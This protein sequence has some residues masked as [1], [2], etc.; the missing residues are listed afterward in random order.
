MGGRTTKRGARSF[1][2]IVRGRVRCMWGRRKRER[3]R[4]EVL[5]K[6]DVGRDL[7]DREGWRK[8]GTEV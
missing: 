8:D 2:E 6:G 7:L 1:K 5:E 3:M 4:K